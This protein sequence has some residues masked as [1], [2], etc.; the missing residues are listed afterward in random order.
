MK[1][2]RFENFDSITS[3]MIINHDNYIEIDCSEVFKSFATY[4]TEER[5]KEVLLEIVE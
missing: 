4:Q 3:L 5:A 2:N 1:Q